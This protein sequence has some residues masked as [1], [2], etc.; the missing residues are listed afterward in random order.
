MTESD[1]QYRTPAPDRPGT[2]QHASSGTMDA[3]GSAASDT[4]GTAKEQTRQVAGEVKAQARSLATDARNRMGAEVQGQNDRLA[5]SLRHFAG[6]LDDMVGDRDDSPA[7][8][9]VL[10]VSQ[11]GRRVADYLA[12]HGPD[13]VLREVRDFAR[14]RPGTFLTVAAV[15]GFVAGRLGKGVLGAASADEPA[16]PT[17]A[18]QSSSAVGSNARPASV[19]YVPLAG[20]GYV[21]PASAS[22]VQPA[23]G[24]YVRSSMDDD[25]QP[26]A[27][28]YAGSARPD[29]TR[30]ARP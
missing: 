17:S 8:S 5:E 23:A 16:T 19:G 11:G 3:L 27:T 13:G 2:G 12:Q 6:E 30:E 15:A 25:V 14:R 10:Q 1:Y 21:Q 22:E 9:V 4:A 24:G 18:P 28:G 26:V 7:R 29:P 20:D